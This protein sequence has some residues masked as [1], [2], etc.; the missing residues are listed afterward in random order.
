MNIADQILKLQDEAR[1]LQ[2]QSLG[3]RMEIAMLKGQ[4]NG[5]EQYQRQMYAVIKK[6]QAARYGPVDTKAP[7][8]FVTA[9]EADGGA[10]R[11]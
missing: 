10:I 6:Q 1:A 9:G 3:K 11:A 5:V 7:C 2:A 4:R 8:Y